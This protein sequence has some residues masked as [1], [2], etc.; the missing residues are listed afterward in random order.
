MQ[1]IGY[2]GVARVKGVKEVGVTQRVGNCCYSRGRLYWQD[3]GKLL[4]TIDT[5]RTPAATATPQTE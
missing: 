5:T 3:I 4:L 1:G 2:K